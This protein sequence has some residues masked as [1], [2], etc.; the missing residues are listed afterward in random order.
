MRQLA[1][2][3]RRS[4]EEQ[5]PLLLDGG[6]ATRLEAMGHRL[7]SRLWSAELLHS[8]PDA[9]L[10]A[11]LSYLEAGADC[12]T[13][14]SYQATREGFGELGLDDFE[15]DTLIA[16]SVELAHEAR[17][18]YRERAGARGRD[19]L[20]AASIGPYG[21][22]LHD[23]SEYRGDYH[24][25]EQTLWDFHRRRLQLLDE[26]DA[27][28]L[29][30]ETIPDHTEARVL[31]K[32]LEFASTPA[33]VSFQC[34]D[35]RHI[36]DGTPVRDMAALFASHDGVLAV[37]VN[38]TAPQ[39]VPSLIAECRAGAPDKT[40]VVY[41]NSGERYDAE[42]KSWAGTATPVEFGSAAREWLAAGA[43]WIGGCCRVGPDHIAAMRA[44][45][46]APEKE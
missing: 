6:L 32:L 5:R 9:V 33:W 27:D 26:C 14:A 38:C 28:L 41:P 44:T 20:V 21:A 2:P 43:R 19:L 30:C 40:I 46:D 37:G 34:R 18:R 15:A 42:S 8:H 25:P 10:E 13:G 3:L 23:G 36:A 4:L 12:I 45:L 35:G 31:R 22:A 24:V 17:R 39:H 1:E 7:D 29:A 11:H 16:K